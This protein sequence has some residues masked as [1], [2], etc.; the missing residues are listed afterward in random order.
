MALVRPSVRA[1]P[2]QLLIIH[3]NSSTSTSTIQDNIKQQQKKGPLSGIT[4]VSLEQAIAAPFCTR[5]LADL[6]A[7]VI[8][9]ERPKVGDFA[10]NY[11]SRVNGLSSHFVWTNRSKE[12]LALDVKNARDHRILMRL[13]S[14]TDV[15][16]QN[17]APGA[18]ARLGLSF[19]DLSEKHPSLIVCNISGYGPDGPYRDKK[20]YD[21]LIQSE[22]GL[23]SVTGTATEP[24]KVGISIA[25]ICA[26]SYAYSNILAALFERE[27]DPERR[28]RNIDISMLE[29]MVEWMGFPM[30][31]TYGDQPGPTP[32][33]AAHAA[34]YP[35]GPFETGKGTVML[36]IQN[37]REWAKFCEMVLEKPEMTTDERFCNN[38]LRVKNRDA[39]RETIC[40]VFAAYSAEGVLRRLDEAGIANAIVNDMQGVWNHPQLRARQR[41][42]QIQTPA[43]A[44][45]ALFPPGTGPDGFEAQMGA[46]PEI[47]QHNEAILAELGID[48]DIE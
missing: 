7:R 46:V 24:A 16:V 18:S 48:T 22:A 4:V 14:R 38:S 20:A 2:R 11:D 30:Y 42:T 28:G 1:L 15:L 37:E 25:D 33:G 3:R 26:G 43:G 17:L 13:L 35:Y 31:Y 5:Q 27:R 23:L 8:K 21:L 36:G 10:R 32:A 40:K 19:A 6:G 39:L 29:S 41:W 44:V 47:G 12:S 34:I 9:I 45:P